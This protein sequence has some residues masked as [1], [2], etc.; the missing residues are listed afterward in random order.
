MPIE[1]TSLLRRAE[2]ALGPR[3]L[4]A[5]VPLL[6]R[7]TARRPCRIDGRA[8]DPQMQWILL[9]TRLSGRVPLERGT[10]ERARREY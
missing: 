4:R 1:L 9:V 8:L 6:E 3:L 7:I 5:P 10:V 2:R